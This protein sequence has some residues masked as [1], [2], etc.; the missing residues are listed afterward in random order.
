MEDG[1]TTRFMLTA[2]TTLETASSV[3]LDLRRPAYKKCQYPMN[4]SAG[5]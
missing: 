4:W 3:L 2:I 5:G 1:Y